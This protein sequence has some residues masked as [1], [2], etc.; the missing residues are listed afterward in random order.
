MRNEAEAWLY[1]AS[2]ALAMSEFDSR[3]SRKPLKGWHKSDITWF[4]FFK[5]ISGGSVAHGLQQKDQ[6]NWSMERVHARE[7][8]GLGKGGKGDQDEW[9]DSEY[10]QRLNDMTCWKTKCGCWV[11]RAKQGNQG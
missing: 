10:V 3:N 9:S 11:V 1:R 6:Q 2:E 5:T 7:A 8:K 4:K